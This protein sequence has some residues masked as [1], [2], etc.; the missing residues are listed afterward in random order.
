MR[1]GC[2]RSQGPS[3]GRQMPGGRDKSHQEHGQ[4]RL[5]HP[6]QS[7]EKGSPVLALSTNS[8][9]FQTWIEVVELPKKP[10]IFLSSSLGMIA[11]IAP[12]IPLPTSSVGS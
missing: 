2:R 9:A 4:C 11:M 3:L 1:A 12:Q 10:R 7:S 5:F 6:S 8:G